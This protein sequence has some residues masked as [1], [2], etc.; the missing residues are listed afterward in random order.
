MNKKEKSKNKLPEW[1][2]EANSKKFA[3][4][5]V[6]GIHQTNVKP[7]TKKSAL[8]V[9]QHYNNIDNLCTEILHFNR[10]ALSLAITLIESNSPKHFAISQELIRKL[11]PYFGN[12]IRIGITGVPGAGKSSFIEALGIFLIENGHKVAV[13]AIDP[14]ST[15]S[16]GSILG[17][18][19]RMEKLSR[20]DNS[21]IR[22]SPSSG[23]LGGVARKTRETI[24]ACEA[25]GFD[26]IL[27]ETIGVGQSEITVRSI[28][29]FFILVQITGS[30][31]ELQTIKKGIIELADLILINKADGDN[32]LK[33][34][35]TRNECAQMM[36]Y[37]QPIT[38]D[39][40]TPVLTSSA[41]TG[42][43]IERTWT[44]INQFM[45]ITKENGFFEL[46][47]INQQIEWLHTMLLEALTNTFFSNKALSDK[48]KQL[49]NSVLE[50]SLTP[51]SA[52]N[53]LIEN[54]I[55]SLSLQ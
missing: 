17:D 9:K 6:S 33:A 53:L 21:F 22:P 14:S 27:I 5:I 12:S 54:Y 3:S 48:Y 41:L 46:R 31:D 35:L 8:N 30:G 26:V 29:D 42:L 13:L 32:I 39:W 51:T 2:T 10:T 25:A 52:V 16:K 45:E 43:N 36:Q 47:R 4:R 15:I 55:K 7:N 37:I 18:K 24:I 50:G 19:T 11:L 23:V 49:Q 40:N 20:Y 34:E 1:N 38:K 44:V 28:V